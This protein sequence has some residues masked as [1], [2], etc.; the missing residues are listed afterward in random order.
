LGSL[1][2][3]NTAFFCTKSAQS[4][5][6]DTEGSSPND[7]DKGGRTYTYQGNTYISASRALNDYLLELR[8][9]DNLPKYAVR[10]AYEDSGAVDLMY[11][12][13]D[14]QKLAMKIWGSKEALEKEAKQR[15]LDTEEDERRRK[16]V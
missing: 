10:D 11:S 13:Q 15:Q 5:P 7:I 3:L 16:R 8:D 2:T 12:L 4:G 1:P 9:L 6:R 14:V